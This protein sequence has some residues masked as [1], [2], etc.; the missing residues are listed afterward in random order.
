MAV[1]SLDG[2]ARTYGAFTAV[3]PTTLE[4]ASGEF[5]AVLGPSG[6]GK[7]TLLRLIAGY[8]QP[9]GGTVAIDGDDI[10]A[11]P[12]RERGIGMVFQNYALFPHMSVFE[13]VAF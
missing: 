6:C 13:N 11:L 3:Q 2:V 8:E 5:F 12:P 1:L 9:D 10:T 4:I 7:T